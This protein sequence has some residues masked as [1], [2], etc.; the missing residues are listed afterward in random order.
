[1]PELVM[2]LIVLPLLVI[3]IVVVIFIVRRCSS[4]GKPS[5]PST[6]RVSVQ[7]RLLEID[8][9]RSKNL[10]SDTEYEEKRRQILNAI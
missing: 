3:S 6:A 8:A 2:L 5:L 10:I 9:L 4:G 7:D 1:M